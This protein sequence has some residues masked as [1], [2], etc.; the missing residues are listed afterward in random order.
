MANDLYAVWNKSCLVTK[1]SSSSSSSSDPT[2]S[3]LNRSELIRVCLHVGLRPKIA[4]QLA[5]EVFEKLGRDPR[6]SQLNF[7][8][9]VTLLQNDNATAADCEADE[10]GGGYAADANSY[11]RR[12]ST[13]TQQDFMNATL[14]NSSFLNCTINGSGGVGGAA[15][16][17]PQSSAPSSSSHDLHASASGLFLILLFDME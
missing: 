4:D 14:F 2:T 5:D 11:Y 8:E 15:M 1:S 6:E 3:Y 10:I 7:N 16:P 13:P 17:P 12:R 9:F